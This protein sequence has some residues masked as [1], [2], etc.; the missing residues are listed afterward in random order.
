[1]ALLG[2]DEFFWNAPIADIECLLARRHRFRCDWWLPAPTL[3]DSY[4][5]CA[6]CVCRLNN[7]LANHKLICAVVKCRCNAE[8]N[9]IRQRATIFLLCSILFLGVGLSWLRPKHKLRLAKQNADLIVCVVEVVLWR[10]PR[11]S[12]SDTTTCL[13]LCLGNSYSSSTYFS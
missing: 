5:L 8:Y 7:W 1:M 11:V 12:T 10:Q 2:I 9:S 13:Y 4:P 3:A 6:A